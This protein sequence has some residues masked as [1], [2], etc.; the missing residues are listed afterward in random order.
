MLHTLFNSLPK[1]RILQVL[2]AKPDE[3]FSIGDIV[4]KARTQRAVATKA[5][6]HMIKNGVVLKIKIASNKKTEYGYQIDE[7]FILFNE[8]RALFLKSQLLMEGDLV[9]QVKKMGGVMLIVLTGIF[10]GG[11]TDSPTDVLIVGKVNKKRVEKLI[12]SFEKKI[13]IDIRYTVMSSTEY[14]YRKDITDRFLYS[15]LEGNKIVVV[16]KLNESF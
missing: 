6:R 15:I 5:L 1:I 8:L 14:K 16:D 12:N 9:K 11:H 7:T 13:N 10:T 4:G 2:L 3:I